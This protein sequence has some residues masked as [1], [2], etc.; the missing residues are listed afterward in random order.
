M[1]GVTVLMSLKSLVTVAPLACGFVLDN[2]FFL[3]RDTSSPSRPSFLT[4]MT[5]DSQARDSLWGLYQLLSLFISIMHCRSGGK[6]WVEFGD[7]DADLR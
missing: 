1:V 4:I 3:G 6:P 5:P 2:I 7:C